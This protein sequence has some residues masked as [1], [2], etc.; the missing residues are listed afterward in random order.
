MKK[1]YNYLSVFIAVTCFM[2]VF[3]SLSVM[4]KSSKTA[5]V[6]TT[7]TTTTTEATTE[8]TTEAATE[9]TTEVITNSLGQPLSEE[10]LI[11]YNIVNNTPK[12]QNAVPTVPTV[13]ENFS[14][15]PEYI[16]SQKDFN[17][18]S[19]DHFWIKRLEFK[20]TKEERYTSDIIIPGNTIEIRY[21]QPLTKQWYMSGNTENTNKTTMFIDTDQYSMIISI[22]AVYKNHYTY[23]T[24]EMVPDLEEKVTIT[25]VD[26]GYKLSYSFPHSTDYIGE[27][28]GLE[29][30]NKLADWN[31]SSHFAVLT[32]DLSQER[33]FS[34]DGYYFPTPYNY[35][36]GGTNVLYRQ[37]SNYS[38]ASFTKYGSF[39]AAFDLGYVTTYTCMQ[40][41]NSDGF[42]STGPKSGWLSADFNI[43]AGFYDTRFNTDFASNLIDAYNRYQN[44][45][46]LEALVIYGEF[47]IKHA[48]EHSYTTKNG[49]ILVEDYAGTGV[50][51]RTHVSLN[52][53]LAELNLLYDMYNLTAEEKY[54]TLADKMLLAIDDTRD[55]W[56]LANSNLNYA[57]EYTGTTNTM[58]DYPYLTYNDLYN[59]KKILSKYFNISNPTIEYL[60]ACKME[61]MQAN[62]VTGYYTD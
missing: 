45:E 53:Q 52:H 18:V 29:S 56:V 6:T 49:G 58:V 44:P 24:L 26:N 25:K 5:A 16:L 27:I 1:N 17:F 4:A 47:F 31:D 50:Y 42:W 9:S 20:T 12:V 30:V 10:E 28:W 40:N 39:P 3:L 54:R 21:V 23:N 48:N 22:P 60:M 36:P 34:W 19:G 59:T 14:D 15:T 8:T 51:N 13:T 38:G 46:F 41:Q 43:G 33:R 37:P 7:T 32:Q 35:V 55:Q 62:N 11:I 57:V 61:W 2:T